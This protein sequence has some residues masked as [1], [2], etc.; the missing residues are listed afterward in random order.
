[1]VHLPAAVVLSRGAAEE[2]LR[3]AGFRTIGDLAS[4]PRSDLARVVGG[5]ADEL[6]RLARGS[7]SEE[8]EERVGEPR[9]R[10]TDFTFD[11]DV[12]VLAAQQRSIDRDHTGRPLN[13]FACDAAGLAVRRILARLI[14]AETVRQRA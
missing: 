9:L 13:A 3:A 6:A 7:P 8:S 5:M 11:E 14:T 10:S 1:M 4:R 2:L 12:A